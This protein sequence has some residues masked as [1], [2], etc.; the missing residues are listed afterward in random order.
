MKKIRLSKYF[1]MNMHLYPSSV[2]AQP[3][4]GQFELNLHH[5]TSG[6]SHKNISDTSVS[7]WNEERDVVQWLNVCSLDWPSSLSFQLVLYDWCNKGCGMYHP[8][9]GLAHNKKPYCWL[10]RVAH[11]AVC[12]FSLSLFHYPSGPVPSIQCHVTINK[13]CCVHH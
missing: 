11:V 2:Y 9:C 7:M 10:E 8:V 12:F 3:K 1:E 13:M 4:C 5:L 6:L